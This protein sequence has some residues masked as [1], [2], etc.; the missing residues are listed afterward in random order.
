AKAKAKR[1]G[2]IVLERVAEAGHVLRS[3]IIECLGSD[4][5][6][7]LRIAVESDSKAA[8]EFFSKSLMPMI[9]AGP[10]GT[11]GY[12][13]GRPK[14]HAVFRYWP[15]LIHR[16]R[17]ASNVEL[18]ETAATSALHVDG[19]PPAKRQASGVVATRTNESVVVTQTLRDIALA[20][21]GDKGIGANIGI[22]AR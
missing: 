15:C 22:I 14:V 13:E 9:T 6:T 1:C 5:E 4:A 12:A 7:V 21:S 8:L 20:R 10:Q 3:H 18:L 19:V 11:T 16:D 2:E 17:V